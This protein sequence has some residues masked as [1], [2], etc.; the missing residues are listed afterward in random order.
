MF[1]K[2][3]LNQHQINLLLRQDNSEDLNSKEIFSGIKQ[4]L[5]DIAPKNKVV[6]PFSINSTQACLGRKFCELHRTSIG[7]FL[8]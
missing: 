3:R 2:S 8:L 4:S 6:L 5:Q 1:T 7:E